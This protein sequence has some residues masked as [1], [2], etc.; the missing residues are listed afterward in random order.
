MYGS[1]RPRYNEA[2][3]YMQPHEYSCRN[4]ISS[5]IPQEYGEGTLI[6]VEMQT[7]KFLDKE[8]HLLAVV[9]K[10]VHHYCVTDRE[11]CCG[12]VGFER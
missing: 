11:Q 6:Q 2:R 8:R 7:E 10:Y 9:A 4:N 12:F 5:E 3:L 1:Q